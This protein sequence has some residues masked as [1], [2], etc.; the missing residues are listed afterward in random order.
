MLKGVLIL[1]SV[2]AAVVCGYLV[3]SFANGFN[4]AHCYESVIAVIRQ[5]AED[6]IK[7][8]P[9]ELPK[10]QRFMESLPLVGYETNCARVRAALTEQASK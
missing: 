4:D 7:V 3:G 8:G 5:R 10:F 9:T 2:I 1:V 6:A